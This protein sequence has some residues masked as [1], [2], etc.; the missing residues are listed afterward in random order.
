MNRGRSKSCTTGRSAT[1]KRLRATS[2]QAIRAGTK[3]STI[4]RRAGCSSSS[5]SLAASRAPVARTTAAART[6]LP[7]L[8]RTPR[9]SLPEIDP[10][11]VGVADD[12]CPGLLRCRSQPIYED[13]PS[14][15]DVVHRVLERALKLLDEQLRADEV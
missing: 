10:L 1:G 11:D 4:R 7:S 14:A 3:P 13:L 15:V 6:E 2:R 12:P 9:A 8:R 5:T